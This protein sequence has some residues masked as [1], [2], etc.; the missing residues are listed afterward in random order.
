MEQ[1]KNCFF[2][3]LMHKRISYDVILD[4]ANYILWNAQI[5]ATQG[6]MARCTVPDVMA[7]Y[8]K[9]MKNMY[10]R[11][12]CD[13]VTLSES[14]FNNKISKYF[15]ECHSV[16]K[17]ND[18]LLF[19]TLLLGLFS[20][21]A[22]FLRQSGLSEQFFA[23]LTLALELNVCQNKFSTI[24]SKE[25]D[26]NSLIEYEEIVLKSGL[27]M[28]E[29][30]L[31]VEK[32][33]Q[34]YYFLPCPLDR[35]CS[36]PQRVVLNEDIYNYIYPLANRDHA[37]TL[38]IIILRLLKIPLFDNCRLKSSIFNAY[39]ASNCDNLCDF[40]CIEEIMPIFLHRTIFHANKT[41]DDILWAMVRDFSIGPSF[42]TTHIGHELYIKYLSEV[43][44][45]CAECFSNR[46]EHAY[47][48]NIFVLLLLRLERI[49]MAFD[50]Y[51]NKWND[52][53][54]KRLRTKV[55]NLLKREENRNCLVFYVEFA[56]IEYDLKRIEQAE[57]IYE[58]AISQSNPTIEDDCT[59]SEYWYVCISL[60]EML[61]RE[62][63]EI[64]ALNLLNAM[65]IGQ[66]IDARDFKSI[67]TSEASNLLAAKKFDD[68]LK[69]VCFIERNVTII[70]MVQSFQP[71]Y[72]ICVIK[73]NIY[74]KLLWRKS[75]DDAVKQMEV[76]LKTFP[77]KNM[78]HMFIRE[79]LYE[80]YADLMLY[81]LARHINSV[82]LVAENDTFS[83]IGR[84]IDEFPTNM[85]LLKC[86]ALCHNQPWHRIRAL[87]TKHHSPIA[88]MFLVV[89]A[90]YRCKKYAV[91]AANQEPSVTQHDE[92]LLT[93]LT[94]DV[95]DIENAYKTRVTNLLKK[96]TDHETPTSK[97][98]LLWR[99]YLRS[100]LDVSNDFEKCRNILLTA[101]NECPWNKV[102][103]KEIQRIL[104]YFI[105]VLRS[106]LIRFFLYI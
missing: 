28:N 33:R 18:L 73:A 47:K 85:H 9:C 50:V 19:S 54:T 16:W 40:D 84:G 77:E 76:L 90:Q 15:L 41:F 71:D 100:L 86:A 21:C 13:E 69:D 5:M 44:L 6:S 99:L 102:S 10:K 49:V 87:F 38:V 1:L 72:L 79:Q 105:C 57:H 98:S 31:R 61:M 22:L 30:W 53:K 95:R 42:I 78:R 8:E 29:I 63:K 12:R 20:S 45:Q 83:V 96:F 48:R 94:T 25:S 56:Q 60:I 103:A 52:D 39:D 17:S 80:I 55:K 101:L 59:R 23:L 104:Y 92:K 24:Q 88:I 70:E 34:N 62:Q 4:P 7:L 51:M 46:N 66:K 82:T 36:D 3:V 11:N 81:K 93:V 91:T 64:K 35:S 26:Q 32:L 67:E 58:A 74:H 89:A 2:F 65:A 97:N 106:K 14:D 27:P 37:F 68:R 75:K 43:L